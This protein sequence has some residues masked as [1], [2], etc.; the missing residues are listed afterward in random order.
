MSYPVILFLKKDKK[1]GLLL[2]GYCQD[3]AMQTGHCRYGR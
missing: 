2:P 1:Y 3:L